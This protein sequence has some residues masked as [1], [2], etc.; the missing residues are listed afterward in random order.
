MKKQLLTAIL[1][2]SVIFAEVSSTAG[3]AMAAEPVSGK[4]E[5]LLA[6]DADE[7]AVDVSNVRANDDIVDIEAE[8]ERENQEKEKAANSISG[9]ETEAGNNAEARPNTK[10]WKTAD[11]I[12]FFNCED[13]YVSSG[14]TILKVNCTELHP[15]NIFNK[16]DF[17]VFQDFIKYA[18]FAANASDASDDPYYYLANKLRYF[19]LM[20]DIDMRDYELSAAYVTGVIDSFDGNQRKISN[21]TINVDSSIKGN[22]TSYGSEYVGLI[23][24]AA[25]IKDLTIENLSITVKDDYAPGYTTGSLY[26]GGIAGKAELNN[27][28]MRGRVDIKIGE[29]LAGH[30][31]YVIGGMTAYPMSNSP[32]SDCKQYANMVVD[33]S[34]VR[35]IDGA[36][37]AE[38]VVGGIIGNALYG[39]VRCYNYGTLRVKNYGFDSALAGGNNFIVGGIA[40][41]GNSLEFCELKE[42][43]LVEAFDA[44][45]SKYPKCTI[46][47]IVGY[48]SE[49]KGGDTLFECYNRGCVRGIVTA[50]GLV[51]EA[52]GNIK[53]CA[54]VGKVE[55]KDTDEESFKIIGGIACTLE[56]AIM[57]LCENKG[58]IVS[59]AERTEIGGLVGEIPS[60]SSGVT[61]TKCVNKG[62]LSGKYE[63]GGLVSRASTQTVFDGCT[64]MGEIE[65]T[66]EWSNASGFIAFADTNTHLSFK[67][68]ENRESVTALYQYDGGAR[69]AGFCGMAYAIDMINCRNLGSIKGKY[70]AGMCYELETKYSKY[71]PTLSACFNLGRIDGYTTAAGLVGKIKSGRV[72]KCFNGGEISAKDSASGLINEA[73]YT[74]NEAQS[75]YIS[76]CFNYGK[77]YTT[78]KE[79]N[80]TYASG[81]I[82]NISMDTGDEGDVKGFHNIVSIVRCYNAGAIDPMPEGFIGYYGNQVLR[83]VSGS[84]DGAYECIVSGNNCYYLDCEGASTFTNAGNWTKNIDLRYEEKALSASA[85]KYAYI[86]MPEIWMPGKE[87]Y[88]YPYLDGVSEN[89]LPTDFD[90]EKEMAELDEILKN[91]PDE[92]TEAPSSTPSKAPTPEPT[93]VPIVVPTSVPASEPA[94]NDDVKKEVTDTANE[95]D[96][97]SKK[98]SD[99]VSVRQ[100]DSDDVT[101]SENWLKGK[102]KKYEINLDSVSS[103]NT[104]TLNTGGKFILRSRDMNFDK[105]AG[106]LTEFTVSADSVD[107][108]GANVIAEK[109]AAMVLKSINK[110]GI[111]APKIIKGADGR[112]LD[113]YSFTISY[114]GINGAL[115]SLRVNVINP[116]IK[117]GIPAIKS[118][119]TIYSVKDNGQTGDKYVDFANISAS[120]PAFV[121][122]LSG[123]YGT[124]TG[125]A[126]YKYSVP[127]AENV[128]SGI[129][130]VGKTV[131]M[132]GKMELIGHKVPGDGKDIAAV[133]L[134]EDASRLYVTPLYNAKGSV[135]AMLTLNGRKYKLNITIK[136]K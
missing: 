126:T 102:I 128:R 45:E 8:A 23:P 69:A 7:E 81:V 24:S 29:K 36:K 15:A 58:E 134:S 46:G 75:L 26:I 62:K 82:G 35:A 16:Y 65:G 72:E 47:G 10:D 121:E 105:N 22:R 57:E 18:T 70:A 101:V 49:K 73:G 43:G 97:A 108:Y 61:F 60:S 52:Y 5:G 78:D 83:R 76:D 71:F 124:S 28:E 11:Y 93:K 80:R 84:G 2:M 48:L 31:K 40:G 42:N 91:L 132:P 41:Y 30:T 133:I 109:A 77:V 50:G 1:T 118:N 95:R 127:N 106:A 54:N 63:V 79:R 114:E 6:A 90:H 111:I 113:K 123:D 130:T 125:I 110:K 68:C 88:P 14:Q 4:A 87:G 122:W 33:A 104:I 66:G 13:Y 39:A 20:N 9:D 12:K 67:D 115:H 74:Y 55:V 96:D 37:S 44:Q 129:W 131:L 53:Y 99:I 112:A 59:N 107:F 34:A 32:I 17:M 19:K 120:N 25:L 103:N 116:D 117:K 51:G 98:D 119:M 94:V 86:Y 136:N 38:V 64:N 56:G 92:P 27:C 85:L 3:Y 135:K 89:A 21:V 100:D